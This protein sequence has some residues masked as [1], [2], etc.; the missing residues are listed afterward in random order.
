MYLQN[1]DSIFQLKW[2]ENV[3]YGDIYHQNEVEQ[4]IYN[5]QESDPQLLRTQFSQHQQEA[6][7]LIEKRLIMP[8][9]E[10][11]LKCSNTF[12]LL[13]ARG[14]IGRDE[15]MASILKIRRL[16]E[17]VARAYLE[18]RIDLGFPLLPAEHREEM[19]NSYR[20]RYLT[21]AT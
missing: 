3:T 19:V 17:K 21:A 8:A 13:D 4:S 14:A 1:V 11:I 5:F 12:N 20:D 18:Q 9:Y 10:Q 6:L 15:R 16:S 7:R 2:N